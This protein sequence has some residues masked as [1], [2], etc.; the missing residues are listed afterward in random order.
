MSHSSGHSSCSG[1]G[2][3]WALRVLA[4]VALLLFAP[5]AVGLVVEGL[6]G[7]RVIIEDGSDGERERAFEEAFSAVMLKVTGHGRWLDHPDIISAR[8]QAGDF[9]EAFAYGTEADGNGGSERRYLEVDFA[10]GPIND[11]L[12]NAG[13]PRWGSNRPSVLVWMVVQDADGERRML[14]ATSDPETTAIIEAVAA[15]RGLPVIFPLLDFEDLRA[16][17]ADVLWSLDEAAL[18]AAGERY[19]ADSILAGRMQR[20][21][22]GHLTGLWQFIFQDESEVFDGLDSQLDLYL[23]IP[24]HRIT[25]QLADYFA[26]LR[27]EAEAGL[28]R[29]QVE[30]V[31]NLEAYTALLAYLQGLEPVESVTV[32]EI[33]GSRLELRIGL[34]GDLQQLTEV[35]ALERNLLPT[36]DSAERADDRPRRSSRRG[37]S[38][39]LLSYRWTR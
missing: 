13:I 18:R 11:L 1:V 3:V 16:L 29:L 19:A 2:F 38:T 30:E 9:V 32:G 14:S 21:R 15:E 39:P 24:M 10:E 34:D 35:I 23:Q 33:D 12:R 8:R 5:M 4:V 7:H 17:S 25:D 22:R 37:D 28:V 36:E 31:A 6:Y 27:L 26:P 20:T